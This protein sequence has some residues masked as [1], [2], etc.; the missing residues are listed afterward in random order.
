MN[1]KFDNDKNFKFCNCFDVLIS[2]VS[3]I[4]LLITQVLDYFIDFI[5]SLLCISSLKSISLISICN[6]CILVF[7][8]AIEF[9]ITFVNKLRV[10]I[11]IQ[12]I[13]NN[14]DHLRELANDAEITI[15]SYNVTTIDGYI[16]GLHRC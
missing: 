9:I 4:V 11:M 13:D 3:V 14:N 8:N 15:E 12:N 6:Y 16:L 10:M 7:I 1:N 5:V 2:I